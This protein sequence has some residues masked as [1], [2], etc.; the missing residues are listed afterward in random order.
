MGRA[1]ATTVQSSHAPTV[2]LLATAKAAAR[3]K[4]R[5]ASQYTRI[6]AISVTPIVRVI[7]AQMADVAAIT[8]QRDCEC[9]G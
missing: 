8:V 3:R 2:R 6:A 4:Y 5:R 7:A 1:G 9:P